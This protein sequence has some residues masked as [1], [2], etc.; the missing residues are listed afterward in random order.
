MRVPEDHVCVAETE[1]RGHLPHRAQA[2]AAQLGRRD[3]GLKGA[4]A[5][6]VESRDRKR[7]STGQ[8][9]HTQIE[10]IAARRSGA[11]ARQSARHARTVDCPLSVDP[12]GA[13]RATASIH[14]NT[15]AV[16]AS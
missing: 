14:A 5:S 3:V 9:A 12:V 6:P 13:W 11:F 1:S 2:R 16:T 8:R 15:G 10:A 7:E 4:D